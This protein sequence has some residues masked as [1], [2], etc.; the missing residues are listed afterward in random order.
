MTKLIFAT[1]NKNKLK[2]V[3]SLIPSTI[4]LL[5]LDDINLLEEIEE[6]ALTIEGNAL[7]KAQTIYKQTGINCFADDSGLLVDALDGAPG[8]YSARYAGEHKN[9]SDN[10]EKLLKDL[11]DKDNRNAHFKTVMAL[12]I[13]G[14]EYLFEGIING[15]ITT[16]KSGANGFGYDPIFLPN[17]YTETFAEMSS[18]IK[19][20]ISHRAK[21]MKQ[22]VEFV[23][24]L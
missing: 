3:K 5:S 11:S 1:H 2:E 20:V 18:D 9:D 22:L 6:T 15:I 12:I 24:S 8:V 16:E 21:A 7:L 4:E 14:K 19:N 13:D 17:G 23:N 10:L